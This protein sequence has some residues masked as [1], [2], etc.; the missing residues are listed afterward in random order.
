MLVFCKPNKPNYIKLN[1]YRL[2]ALENTIRKVLESIIADY[3]SYLCE[4]F[5]LLP[6]HYFSGQLEYTTENAILILSKNIHRAQK[7]RNIFSAIFIDIAG[8]FN[9]I[10]H[11]RLI[12]NIR[13]HR[14]FIEITRQILLFLSN[15]TTRIRL[16]EITTDRIPTPTGIPQG[17]LL[18]L[19]LYIFYNSDLLN[20]PKREKQLRIGYIDDILY[21]IQN[22]TAT[23]NTKELK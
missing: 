3:I 20:I 1:V 5:N 11:E 12:Y 17:L 6:K 2:I 8:V 7:K 4:T 10:H 9:N 16:N 13:K 14:I 18:S 23:G 19:I 15:R 22:K 21:R